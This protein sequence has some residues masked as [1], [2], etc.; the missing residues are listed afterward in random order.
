MSVFLKPSLAFTLFNN[1]GNRGQESESHQLTDSG[2][3]S[4]HLVIFY[5]NAFF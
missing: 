5:E 2:S 4:L 1:D 3:P